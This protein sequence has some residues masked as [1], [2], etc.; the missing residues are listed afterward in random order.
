MGNSAKIRHRRRRRQ[1]LRRARIAL[2]EE[3]LRE[4]TDR[5]VVQPLQQR[6]LYPL[7]VVPVKV[8]SSRTS[9]EL[10]HALS[11]A[12]RDLEPG[13]GSREPGAS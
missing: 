1:D 3:K 6:R 5:H 8:E 10:D 4:M 2:L 9:S 7:G 13:V 12:L 11:Q